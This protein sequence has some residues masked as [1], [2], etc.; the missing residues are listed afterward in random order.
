MLAQICHRVVNL[1]GPEEELVTEGTQIRDYVP[2]RSFKSILAAICL[3]PLKC[4]VT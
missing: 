3:L 4:Y 2:V 1:E